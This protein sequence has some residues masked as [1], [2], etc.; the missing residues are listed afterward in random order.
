M[1][2]T[3]WQAAKALQRLDPQSLPGMRQLHRY[4][5][6]RWEPGNTQPNR[7]YREL[8][9]QLLNAHGLFDG[10]YDPTAAPGSTPEGNGRPADSG[11]PGVTG[12]VGSRGGFGSYGSFGGWLV[13]PG[14]PGASVPAAGPSTPGTPPRSVGGEYPGIGLGRV[15]GMAADDAARDAAELG[16]G[17]AERTLE[18]LH[19]DVLRTARGY[20]HRPLP[21]VFTDARGIREF[22][23]ELADRTRRPDQLADLNTVAG[24]ACG[25][26]SMAAF[27]MGYWEPAARFADSAQSYASLAGH[28]S[29]RSWAMGAQAF[30]ATW[31]G[32]PE[33]AA[34]HL[35][36]ALAIAPAG[37]AVVRLHVYQARSRALLGDREGTNQAA[38]AAEN[39]GAVESRD[40][41]H[42]VIGGEFSYNQARQVFNLGTA[43]ISLGDGA[44]AEQHAQRAL[45]LYAALP[46]EQ[47]FYYDE[48]AARVDLASARIM[49][50][51]LAGARDA[52]TPVFALPPVQRAAGITSR[53]DQV[54]AL[55][56]AEVFRNSRE[57]AQ[58][59]ADI[60]DFTTDTTAR[61]LPQSD[62]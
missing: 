30:I 54:R 52:L 45:D 32:R 22:A 23:V 61:A 57:T 2:P 27:D 35:D 1:F 28:D 20:P 55:L 50:G 21:E 38:R 3:T 8:I 19:G 58:L 39:A 53:L 51:D 47:R 4:W 60:T 5:S 11:A 56:A 44:T 26:L 37:T 18:Q 42:D 49:R 14:Y 43:Y 36:A 7:N 48:N 6:Q 9:E 24:Q 34:T 25:L 15:I 10:T 12:Q 62:L 46:A 17:H 29:L 31:L 41:L 16:G 33:N 13:H 59:T 40:E